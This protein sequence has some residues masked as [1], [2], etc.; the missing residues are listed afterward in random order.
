[1]AHLYFDRELLLLTPQHDR[2]RAHDH[3]RVF[4][5]HGYDLL[6]GKDHIVFAHVSDYSREPGTVPG[7]GRKLLPQR[8]PTALGLTQDSAMAAGSTY[9]H[10]ES[11]YP[12]KGGFQH[13]SATVRVQSEGTTLKVSVKPHFTEDVIFLS[14]VVDGTPKSIERS[15]AAVTVTLPGLMWSTFV[16]NGYDQTVE[17]ISVGGRQYEVT[18]GQ[19]SEIPRID[20]R[21]R[22]VHRGIV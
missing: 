20:S 3:L 10:V 11:C 13:R 4:V 18:N 12:V 16:L 9:L 1:M 22:R 5:S 14:E 21:Y 17:A 2:T 8:K 7:S 19:L 15:P 6:D